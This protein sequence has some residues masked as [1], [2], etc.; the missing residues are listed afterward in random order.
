MKQQMVRII[1]FFLFFSQG[2]SAQINHFIYLQTENKQPFY[3]K[4]DKV[5]L[6]SSAS[7]YLIIPKLKDGSYKLTV[8]FP[9]NEWQEQV[10][11]YTVQQL[12]AGYL[13]KNFGEKGWGLFNFQSLDITMSLNSNVT[14]TAKND[15]K[16]DAFSALLSNVVN[17]PA[18]LKK[19]SVNKIA[20]KTD[21]SDSIATTAIK[22]TIAIVEPPIASK[23]VSKIEKLAETEAKGEF[24]LVYLDNSNE[25]KDSIDILIPVNDQIV[26]K[27]VAA[28]TGNIE[29]KEGAVI[30]K[31][32]S[33][34]AN[35]KETQKIDGQQDVVQNPIIEPQKVDVK[36]NLPDTLNNIEPLIKKTAKAEKPAK[37]K[38]EKFLP[39][40]LAVLTTTSDTI[41]NTVKVTNT[42]VDSITVNKVDNSIVKQNTV[43]INSD[44]ITNATDED[45]L[46]LRK[47]MAAAATDEEMIAIAK[48]VLKQKCFSTSQI[49]NLA[50]LFLKD[51]GRYSFFDLA[52]PFVWDSYNF[53]SLENQLSDTYFINRFKAMIRH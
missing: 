40:E 29:V 25:K 2:A 36:E 39:I 17:D 37:V 9:K 13:L 23:P 26:E 47:K 32:A 27:K 43:I 48:K 6:S 42:P 19:E 41:T 4:L 38:A 11:N 1:I 45:F 18:I 8:G 52:Y 33:Q 3:V 7:G 20:V 24:H 51:D 22:S 34:L 35:D 28:A 5:L 15:D 10:F 14:V 50:V 12:D 53:S 30:E 49:K 44:C 31:K 16:T 21:S 46:K